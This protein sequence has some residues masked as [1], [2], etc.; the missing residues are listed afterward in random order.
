MNSNAVE[1]NF[2]E[3][4]CGIRTLRSIGLSQNRMGGQLPDCISSMY[5]LRVLFLSNNSFDGALPDL[6]QLV[7]M[8]SLLVDDNQLSGDVTS[9]FN[10][11]SMLR[12]LYLV[13]LFWNCMCRCCT[14]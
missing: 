10:G 4:L 7:D 9:M 2:P 3:E 13:S 11:M 8:V 12:H 14:C 6:S 1:G 5:D